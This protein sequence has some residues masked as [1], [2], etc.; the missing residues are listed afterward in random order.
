LNILKLPLTSRKLYTRQS[1]NRFVFLKLHRG[2]RQKSAANTQL[3]FFSGM[4]GMKYYS[5]AYRGDAEFIISS[6]RHRPRELPRGTGNGSIEEE[7]KTIKNI[8]VALR[9]LAVYNRVINR[10]SLEAP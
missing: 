8:C 9:V 3:F 1:P 2:R 7:G 5:D 4:I 6:E 10:A